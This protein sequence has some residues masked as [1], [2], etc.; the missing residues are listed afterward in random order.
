[1]SHDRWAGTGTAR[2]DPTALLVIRA[3]IESGASVPLRAEVRVSSD[4]S[5]GFERTHTFARAEAVCATVEEWLA[6]ILSSV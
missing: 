6:R 1:M 5:A 2:S 4:V 3:W